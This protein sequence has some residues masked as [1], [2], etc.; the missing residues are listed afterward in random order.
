M[1]I[2]FDLVAQKALQNFLRENF[3]KFANNN[4]IKS[5]FRGFSKS[6]KR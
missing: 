6:D 2:S 4:A 1:I 5:G 3:E